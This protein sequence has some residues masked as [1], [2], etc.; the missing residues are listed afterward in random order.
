LIP[1][2]IHSS[3]TWLINDLALSL[4]KMDAIESV[5]SINSSS[6]SS[7]SSVNDICSS[8]PS[9]S[10][11]PIESVQ[12][13]DNIQ[14]WNEMI[15]D[16][17][18]QSKS[19]IEGSFCGFAKHSDNNLIAIC[20]NIRRLEPSNGA[21]W[22]VYISYNMTLDFDTSD[23]RKE[24]ESIK[25]NISDNKSIS[26]CKDD[27]YRLDFNDEKNS[28]T[29]AEN[30]DE[31][32]QTIAGEYSEYYDTQHLI[33]NGAFG[34]VRLATRK[35]TGILAVA[36]FVC[37]SKVFSESWVPSPKRGNRMVPIELHLLE[38]LSHPNIVKLLDVFENDLYYQLV[39][40]KLD[41]GMDLFEFIEQQPKLDEPL[42]SYIFRQ[43]V[44]AV[45]YL[46]SKNIVHRDLKDENVI[47]DQNFSCKLIDFGSAAYFG[48]NFVFSTFCGTM[49][50][51]SPEVLKGNK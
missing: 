27:N 39:M 8:I 20:F 37:K 22:A 7:I 14:Q 49:E 26:G 31:N 33:G 16:R 24:E 42:T 10:S 29:T 6:H 25:E 40:E 9:T 18:N 47:I 15:S 4:H 38:T 2:R 3:V 30:D 13:S 36:K 35:D 34:S 1:P 32:A 48:H 46:H 44:N 5:I 12:F 23:K 19:I 28:M 11:Q 43:V 41:C 17:T 50:Y 21:S 51:C 45:A